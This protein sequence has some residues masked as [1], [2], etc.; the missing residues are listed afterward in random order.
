MSVF[1][2]AELEFLRTARIA[3]LATLSPSGSPQVKPVGFVVDP[4][5]GAID[6]PGVDN[7]STQKW[8]NV[9]RDGRVALVVDDSGAGAVWSPRVLEVRG[10]AELL[11]DLLPAA[12]FPGVAPGVIRIHPERI[13]VFGV[14][15]DGPGSRDVPAA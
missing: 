10:R 14:E 8:R 3:R 15:Q 7:P 2:S 13:V 1:T 5:T 12:A 11:P 9:G 6:V 4:A